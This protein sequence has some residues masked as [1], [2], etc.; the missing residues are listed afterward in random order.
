MANATHVALVAVDPSDGT[1]VVERYVVVHDCGRI[2]NPMVVNGQI[3]GGTVQRLGEALFE[4][5][6]HDEEGQLLNASLLEYL[7][8]TSMDVPDIEVDHIETPAVDAAGGFKGVGEGGVIGAVPA[9]A[10]TIADALAGLGANV[11]F[12]PLPPS[13]VLSLIYPDDQ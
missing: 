10:N 13:R 3:H 11:N 1:T 2:I 12:V 6:Y 8:P 9:I 4:E 7:L 5:L